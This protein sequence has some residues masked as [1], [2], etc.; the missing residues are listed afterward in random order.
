MSNEKIDQVMKQIEPWCEKM[1]RTKAQIL[2]KPK[3]LKDIGAAKLISL[4]K[5]VES[6]EGTFSPTTETFSIPLEFVPT[7]TSSIPVT[8][9]EEQPAE[10]LL[11][12]LLPGPQPRS[13]VDNI[14]LGE[15]MED[16]QANGMKQRIVVRTSPQLKGKYEILDGNRRKRAAEALHW[17]TIKVVIRHVSDAE[18]YE[19]AF[20]VN[21]NRKELSDLEI[22]RYLYLLQDMF[23][24]RYPTQNALAK[25]VGL[26]QPHVSRL[27][28]YY[29]STH[30]ELKK[31]AAKPG[32]PLK[33][34]IP[35]GINAEIELLSEN[36]EVIIQPAPSE[37]QQMLRV[38]VKQKSPSVREL[39]EFRRSLDIIPN[40]ATKTLEQ[41]LEEIKAISLE[42][43]VIENADLQPLPS[44]AVAEEVKLG[45]TPEIRRKLHT[46]ATREVMKVESVRKLRMYLEPS[47]RTF[48]EDMQ[49]QREDYAAQEKAEETKRRSLVNSLTEYYSEKVTRPVIDYFGRQSEQKTARAAYLFAELAVKKI[50]ELSL[51]QEILKEVDKEIG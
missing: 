43:Y 34:L 35:R 31:H 2:L 47:Q 38:F 37:F 11:T 26:T 25:L 18:A 21:H 30:P 22:G 36:F 17:L 19:Y 44:A 10:L 42:R 4:N 49:E 12:D 39:E 6:V 45:S 3:P 51:V 7:P 5:L 48:E 50:A 9:V 40:I 41:I 8:I 20:I 29:I 13:V 46:A 24:E 23:P 14:S 32:R 15:L 1:V 27:V 16:I 28:S 33:R